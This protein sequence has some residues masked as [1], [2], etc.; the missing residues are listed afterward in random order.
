MAKKEIKDF[1]WFI[2]LCLMC[3]ALRFYISCKPI[4][5]CDSQYE[6]LILKCKRDVYIFITND[7]GTPL[8]ENNS[9]Y[10]MDTRDK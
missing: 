7:N 1:D 6:A 4:T 9:L 8:Q 3:Y 5:S 2:F 10:V